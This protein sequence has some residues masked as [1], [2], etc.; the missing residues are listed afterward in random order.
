MF[1]IVKKQV[2]NPQVVLMS[3]DAPLIA[4]KAEPGQ[5]IIFRIAEGGE[6]IPLTIAD[7]DREVGTV[8]IIYQIVG[9]TTRE[10]SE[11]NEGDSL[12]DFVGP[13]G[14][15]SH[16]DGYK[17]VAVIG[18]GLGSA[19][20]YPQAKKLHSLGAEVHAITG[21]RNKDLIIL[22]EEME[23]V[24]NKLI[25]A[26]DDGSN[27]NKGFVTNVLKQLIDE[28]NKYDLVIAIGPL[29]MMKAVSNLTREYGI[30]TLVSMN[31]VMID[32][33]GMCG[34]CRLTV[35][36]KTKF[37]CVDG[38]DFDGHEVDFDEAMRRQNMYKKQEKESTDIHVCRLGGAKNA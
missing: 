34:G 36:G 22:E 31:P 27:G 23:K 37:A 33:T 19:I 10:L 18:G 8:T 6:R 7:Y 16:L 12:L 30:K 14:V 15:A 21:F 32:G 5:F 17:K 3:I 1:K 4:K 20:A 24:S 28:G 2:L 26:T 38:P 25:V 35:G 13:L 9:K 29:V 11:M